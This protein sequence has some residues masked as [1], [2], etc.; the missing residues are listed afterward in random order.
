L[1]DNDDTADDNDDDIMIEHECSML[2][3]RA[4]KINRRTTTFCDKTKSLA[5]ELFSTVIGFPIPVFAGSED[6]SSKAVSFRPHTFFADRTNTHT[7]N[8]GDATAVLAAAPIL[9]Q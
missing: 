5:G 9:S 6:L 4:N 2:L 1:I 3:E 7:C 8:S